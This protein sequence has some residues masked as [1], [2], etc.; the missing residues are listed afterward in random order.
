ML[1]VGV[2]V[3]CDGKINCRWLEEEWYKMVVDYSLELF[4]RKHNQ[5]GF[6]TMLL[7]T[8]CSFAALAVLASSKVFYVGVAES[9]GEFGAYSDTK[10]KGTGLPGRFGVEYSF[11]DKKGVDVYVDQHK[12]R[13]TARRNFA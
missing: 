2:N 3:V 1:T 12:V 9:G 8:F 7:K 5:T 13:L 11:I 6:V 4:L 10:Q